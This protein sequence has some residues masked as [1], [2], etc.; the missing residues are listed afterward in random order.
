MQNI[1]AVYMY[2]GIINFV[3]NTTDINKHIYIYKIEWK[4]SYYQYLFKLIIF[5]KTSITIYLFFWKIQLKNILK[6]WYGF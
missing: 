1:I 3:I 6:I 4:I 2:I 5:Y